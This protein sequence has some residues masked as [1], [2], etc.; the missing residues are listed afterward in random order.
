M[1]GIKYLL[2]TNILIG[3]FTNNAEVVSIAHEKN[4]M[5]EDCGISIISRIELLSYPHLSTK[6]T[7]ALLE[8]L[9]PIKSISIDEKIEK[10]TIL[11]RKKLKLKIPDA[12][13]LATAVTNNLELITLDKEL[14]KKSLLGN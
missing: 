9:Q 5:L 1:S 4:L 2:D 6:E 10:K 12:I 14:L 3:L 8:K 13:I 11:L 7:N